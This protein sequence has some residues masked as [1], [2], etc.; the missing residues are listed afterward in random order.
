M[1]NLQKFIEHIG[2]YVLNNKTNDCPR[3]LNI[4]PL[5]T[6]LAIEWDCTDD[7]YLNLTHMAS[8]TTLKRIPMLV[9]KWC[10]LIEQLEIKNFF[11]E[12]FYANDTDEDPDIV[13]TIT[14]GYDSANYPDTEKIIEDI[15]DDITDII[16]VRL[17]KVNILA[18]NRRVQELVDIVNP[19]RFIDLD[20]DET[21]P[22]ETKTTEPDN[23]PIRIKNIP[24][25]S[26][27]EISDASDNI[28]KFLRDEK[29]KILATNSEVFCI[30]HS[31][32]ETNEKL[33]FFREVCT[34]KR[35]AEMCKDPNST[36]AE[37]VH[38][39]IDDIIYT[40][41]KHSSIKGYLLFTTSI[42]NYG[43]ITSAVSDEDVCSYLAYNTDNYKYLRIG[44]HAAVD[45]TNHQIVQTYCTNDQLCDYNMPEEEAKKMILK[46][47]Q[48]K[49]YDMIHDSVFYQVSFIEIYD[50][51]DNLATLFLP[52]T[53][54]DCAFE[55][56]KW[57]KYDLT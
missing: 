8:L 35:L 3:K 22:E 10:E 37:S 27:T 6:G 11:V 36:S 13:R 21:S 44:F 53:P 47:A 39:K 23:G 12:V 34:S 7:D 57:T 56:D 33:S 40:L 2:Q 49:V 24:K 42:S 5:Q 38:V 32:A 29:H 50:D 16:E 28:S 14:K 17:Y 20:D 26:I 9:N 54:Q 31:Y 51:N 4:R 45:D 55:S 30:A 52:G 46:Y 25:Y 15:A 48:K 43:A 41:W 1:M 19:E 18:N